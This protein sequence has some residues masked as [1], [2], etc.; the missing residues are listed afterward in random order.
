MSNWQ[1]TCDRNPSLHQPFDR[2]PSLQLLCYDLTDVPKKWC[3]HLLNESINRTFLKLN[4]SKGFWFI[5]PSILLIGL[6]IKKEASKFCVT[7][8]DYIS[9]RLLEVSARSKYIKL[10]ILQY[11]SFIIRYYFQS[12]HSIQN[13]DIFTRSLTR[14]RIFFLKNFRLLTWYILGAFHGNIWLQY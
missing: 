10:F 12:F 14:I 7:E 11:H 2:S 1:I 5:T 3:F 6:T 8:I 4:L 9:V 13:G